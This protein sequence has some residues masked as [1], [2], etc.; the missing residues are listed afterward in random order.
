MESSLT[1]N[2]TRSAMAIPEYGRNVQRMVEHCKGITEQEERQTCANA[3]IKI[4]GQL[5]PHLRDTEEY[6][7]KLWAH[8]FIISDFELEIESPYPMPT[9]EIMVSKPGLLEYPQ[10]RIKYG[11]YGKLAEDW[12]KA[13]MKLE[14]GEEK[15]FLVN[16]LA[17]LLKGSYLIWNKNAVDNST[18]IKQLDAMSDGKLKADEDSF[19][20]T[21]ELLNKFTKY[22]NQNSASD[23]TKKKNNNNNKHNNNNNNRNKNKGK[24]KN[25][26]KK[27]Y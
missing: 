17:N 13:A 26:K 11:H 15:Q 19:L 22:A 16:R 10:N 23:I 25:Y 24:N 7:H 4:M 18:I 6:T 2:T 21:K 14:D 27:S 8:L 5:N 12:I 20:E 1:Y 9:K 3:I